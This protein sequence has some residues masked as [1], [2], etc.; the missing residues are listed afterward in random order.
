MV[1]LDSV[2]YYTIGCS[3]VAYHKTT[4]GYCAGQCE[5]SIRS[6]FKYNRERG[7]KMGHTVIDWEE[8][9]GGGNYLL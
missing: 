4:G 6:R 8:A 3:T 1:S 7:L 2:E 9:I 5:V